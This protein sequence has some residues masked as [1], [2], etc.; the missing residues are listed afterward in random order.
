MN[1]ETTMVCG[2]DLCDVLILFHE[3]TDSI[4]AEVQASYKKLEQN[5]AR[6]TTKD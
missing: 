6:K 2:T 3:L 5:L 4:L 1:C